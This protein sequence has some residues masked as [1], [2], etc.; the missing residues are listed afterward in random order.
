MAGRGNVAAGPWIQT[1]HTGGH[2]SRRGACTPGTQHSLRVTT[3]LCALPVPVLQT[4]QVP[5][6]PREMPRCCSD[7]SVTVHWLISVVYWEDKYW[8]EGSASVL[9]VSVSPPCF[10]ECVM[11]KVHI[12]K[13]RCANK[14]EQYLLTPWVLTSFM[15]YRRG[16]S[17]VEGDQM[18][19]ISV[20][21]CVKCVKRRIKRRRTKVQIQQGGCCV[22]NQADQ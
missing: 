18:L 7:W 20:T 1:V 11:C 13:C 12:G 4:V 6:P 8:G 2:A 16:M 22:V 14:T 17:H 3:L 15:N 9:P 10:E 19:W 5:R 21:L